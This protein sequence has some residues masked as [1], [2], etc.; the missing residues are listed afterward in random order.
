M[1]RHSYLVAYDIR[2]S[3][4]LRKIHK[5]VLAYGY[6]LQYS[7]FWCSLDSVELI[8]LKM[9]IRQLMNHSEDSLMFVSLGPS[10]TAMEDRFEFLGVRPLLLEEGPIII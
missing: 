5:T 3:K 10:E 4:R 8:D 6:A 7:V 1:S 9:E 2:D